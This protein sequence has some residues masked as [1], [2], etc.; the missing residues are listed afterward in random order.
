MN[1]PVDTAVDD[2]LARCRA[3][4]DETDL[5]DSAL[6]IE[7]V[8]YVAAMEKEFTWDELAELRLDITSYGVTLVPDSCG[9]DYFTFTYQDHDYV[10]ETT[11][12]PVAFLRDPEAFYVTQRARIVPN[13]KA[14]HDKRVADAQKELARAQA[15]LERLTGDD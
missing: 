4:A 2:L 8:R 7:Y 11:Q 12:L 5:L 1:E 6:T 14:A 3:V 10:T 9:P 15:N 13:R